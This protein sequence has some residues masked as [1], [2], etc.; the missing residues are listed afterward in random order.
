MPGLKF[1]SQTMGREGRPQDLSHALMRCSHVRPVPRF[2]EER[3]A[4]IESV[5]FVFV[6]GAQS[7]DKA[8]GS[9]GEG[10]SNGKRDDNPVILVGVF[11]E[12]ALNVMLIRQVMLGMGC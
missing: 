3:S 12:V 4:W 10:G 8:V 11:A 5:L 1:T 6:L 7:A 9:T 2:L